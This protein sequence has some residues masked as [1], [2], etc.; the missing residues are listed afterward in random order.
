MAAAP[1]Q[2]AERRP[3]GNR[4]PTPEEI[5]ICRPFVEKHIALVNPKILLLLG[6]IATKTILDDN[7][8]IT[9]LRGQQFTASNPYLGAPIPTH[10]MFHPSY[11][12]RQPLAK[13]ET[14]ADLL[15]FKQALHC[16]T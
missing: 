16:A 11:L 5:D 6:G 3:P 13:R 1:R 7:R 12:L 14:W 8:G 9:K 10:V 4:Q 15:A 2:G